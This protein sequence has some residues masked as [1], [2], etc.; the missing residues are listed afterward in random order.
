M[1]INLNSK[2][3]KPIVG[4]NRVSVFCNINTYVFQISIIFNV[5]DD[6]IA[7]FT[8][9]RNTLKVSKIG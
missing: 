1:F 2:I 8:K 6:P 3:S 9:I 5:R 7:V 4:S